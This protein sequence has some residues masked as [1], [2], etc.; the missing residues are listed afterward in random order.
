[1]MDMNN[2]NSTPCGME[3]SD[4]S[5]DYIIDEIDD[6][7]FVVPK[8]IHTEIE[9]HEIAHI[10]TNEIE[11]TPDFFLKSQNTL[12]NSS[13]PIYITISSFLI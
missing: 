11:K 9:L 5:C 8:S 7:T 2:S 3:I 1:M 6:F 13:P 10:I 4:N 12:L